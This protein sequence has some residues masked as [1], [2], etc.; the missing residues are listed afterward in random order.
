MGDV[1]LLEERRRIRRRA[2]EAGAVAPAVFSFDLHSPWTY[3]A[4][5]RVDRMFAGVTWEPVLADALMLGDAAGADAERARAEARAAA[6]RLPLVWPESPPF[7]R[8]AMRV[9]ALTAAS[10]RAAAFVLAAGRLAY[11]GGFDLDD[12]EILAEA[13]AAAGLP[14]DDCLCAMGDAGLDA[15]MEAAGRRLVARGADRLPVLRVGRTLFCGEDRLGA[16]AAAARDPRLDA[17]RPVTGA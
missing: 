3:L 12:P 14:F 16:A 13:G 17:L 15:P 5:E 10:G 2:E 6:L 8:A 4:A 11:C 7:S 9:A 1:I